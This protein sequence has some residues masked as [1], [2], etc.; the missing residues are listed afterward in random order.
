MFEI[1]TVCTGNICRSPV[2]ELLLRERLADLSGLIHSAGTYDLG[3]R[4]MTAEAQRLA[5]LL[6]VPA[7]ASAAHRSTALTE[8][9]LRSPDL[10]LVMTRDQR[11]HVLEMAPA[12]IRAVFTAREF[13]RLAACANDEEILAAANGAGANSSDRLRA[14]CRLVASL[15]GRVASAGD[16]QDDVIDPYR[17]PWEV[18]ELTASQLVPAMEQ[19]IRVVRLAADPQADAADK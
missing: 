11:R 2:A 3:A 10:I 19:V 4:P 6:G 16:A 17:Q 15:R 8:G 7:E 13:A 1:L 12:R 18:Y 5:S 9:Q 14:A